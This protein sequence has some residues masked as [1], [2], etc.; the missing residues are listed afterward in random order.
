MNSKKVSAVLAA[1]LVLALSA[2][3]FAANPFSD[4]PAHHWAY[5]SITKLAAVGLVEGYPDGTFGGTRTMTRYEAAMVFARALARLEALVESQVVSNTAGVQDRIT[6]DILAELESVTDELA[7]LIEAKLADLDVVVKEA[8][9]EELTAAGLQSA[10]RPFVMSEEAEAV[11]AELVGELTKA[12]LAEAKELATETIVETGV[13]ERVVVEDVDEAVVKAIAEEV[14]ASSLWAIEDEIFDNAQYV[15]MVTSRINDR[16]GRV[17]RDV[18]VIAASYVSK[19]EVEDRF[20][21]LE[22]AIESNADYVTMVTN[23]INDRLGRVTKDVDGLKAARTEDL[24]TVNGLIAALQGDVAALQEALD[25]EVLA[26]TNTF[27]K[28]NDE[29]ADELALLGVRVDD[30]EKLYAN[31]DSRV[32]DV[33][34]SVAEVEASVAEVEAAVAELDAKVD[35]ATKVKL[36]G[37]VKYETGKTKITTVVGENTVELDN[38]QGIL[39]NYSKDLKSDTNLEVNL[40]ARLSEGTTVNL[41]LGG[42]TDLPATVDSLNKYVLEVVS[43]TPVNRF[44]VGTV[45]EDVPARFD[46]NALAVKPDR[47]AVADIALGDLNLYALAGQRA[48][49]GMLALGAK[50]SLVPAFGFKLTG[51]AYTEKDLTYADETAVAAGL[52]GTVLGVDYDVKVALD[53]FKAED[54][55]EGDDESKS[56]TNNMLFDVNLGADLGLVSVDAGWTRAGADFGTGKLTGKGFFDSNA[57]TRLRLDAGADLFGVD[58]QAAT[59]LEQD[60]NGDNLISAAMLNAGYEFNLFLPI[61][62]AGAYGWKA[63]QDPSAENDVHTQLKVGTGL[64]LFGVDVDGS[65]T[66]VNNYIDGDWRNPGNWLGKDLNLVNVTLGYNAD[67]FGGANLDLGYN[68]E[69]A[70]PRDDATADVFGNQM[71]HILSAGYG[72]AD[73]MKLN[74]SAK[75]VNINSAE[76]NDPAVN[77]NELKAGLEFSF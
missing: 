73:G 74:M 29:F 59:Y 41:T 65:F 61:N 40:S 20:Y 34:A 42:K 76:E 22:S 38:A 31:L 58:L 49:D 15:E 57:Q 18:D 52:F 39:N 3:V 67:N 8:V 2:S 28:V 13:I 19:D 11:L 21:D 51:A 56:L 66:Y 7:A 72:F 48:D 50:Y 54:A 37:S 60:S 25:A 75:R 35:E 55:D 26:L 17:T 9:A 70:I 33:E 43:D 64:D 27:T 32:T 5:D 14:L 4:V 12:Y 77:V 63:P 69:L 47:G 1:I 23:R 46:T 44:A 30:L 62:L 45:G 24:N 10:D 16:L 6:A 68:F 36:A 71:T 53:R